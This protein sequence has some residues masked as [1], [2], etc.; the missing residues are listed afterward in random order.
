[1]AYWVI[2]QEDPGIFFSSIQKPTSEIL[3]SRMENMRRRLKVLSKGLLEAKSTTALAEDKQL[4]ESK[5]VFLHRTVKDY[6]QSPD[7]QSMLQCWA[8]ETFNVHWEICTALGT[9]AKMTPQEYFI[10][11]RPIWDFAWPYFLRHASSVD[12][13]PA[14]RTD[15]MTMLD[16]LQA[17]IA[18]AFEENKDILYK[19]APQD[20]FRKGQSLEVDLVIV[21]ACA[22]LGVHNYVNEKFAQDPQLCTRVT[23]HVSV[24]VYFNCMY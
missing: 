8:D 19:G 4:F 23:N 13:N 6:L 24:I 12:K 9:L 18:P 11:D 10:P 22:C 3:A 15:L 1:M 2:D 16:H 14:F 20:I 21:S 17:A 5:V 7:A